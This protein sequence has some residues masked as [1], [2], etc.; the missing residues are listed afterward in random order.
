MTN[1]SVVVELILKSMGYMQGMEAAK[2]KT[3]EMGSETEKLAQKREAFNV[4]GTAAIGFGAAVGSG[5]AM[6]VS[7]F[8][9]FDQAMSY[10]QA[11]THE[12]A[13]NM[14]L[15]RD[16][17]LDAGARTV[18]SATES[19]NA[20]EELSKAGVST[21]DILSGGLDAALDLAA[22][23]GLGVADAAGIAA[24]TLKQFNLAGKDASH[25]ADLLAAGAGK[26]QGDVS[27][28]SQALKQGGLVANQFGLSVDETVGTLS[29][30]ASAGM[31]GSDAGT[32][33]RTM[34][35][36]LANPTGEAAEKMKELGIN[37]YDAQGQF[38]GMEGLAG[39]L[40][41]GLSGLTQEQRNAALAIIFGQDA[42]RGANVL[43][44]QGA[45][46]IAEWT[47]KV[48]DQ[49]YA[50][51][52]AAM[53]LDNLKG[54]IEQLGGALDTAFISMG[55]GANGPMRA[56]VQE[57]TGMVDQFNALP[58]W[59]KQAALGIGAVTAAVGLASGAFLLGVPKVA[60][61]KAAI[62]EMGTGAQRA[63]RILGVLGKTA[64]AVAVFFALAKGAEMAAKGLGQMGNDA[65]TANET[66]SYLLDRDYNGIFKGLASGTDGINDMTDAM[67][68]LLATDPGTAFNRW[69]SDLFAFTGMGS[70]VGKAREQFSLMGQALADLVSRG[71]GDRAAEIFDQIRAK[72]E[73]QGYSVKQLNE[74]MPEYQD[75]LKGV[76]NES[77]L[78][79]D[80]TGVAAGGLNDMEAASADAERA[81]SDVVQALQ[82]VAAG[83]LN[84]GDANDKA[85]SA[86]N[87]MTEAANAQGASLYGTDE[88]SIHLRDSIRAV[89][90][91]HRDSAQAI[92]ENNGTLEEAQAKWEE[93]R[94]KVIDM[95][96]AKGE[97]IAVAREWA[98]KNMGSAAQVRDALNG[99]KSAMDA[100]PARKD[101]KVVI[102]TSEA[103]R[104][105]DQWI[106]AGSGRVI[107]VRIAPDGGSFSIGGFK[108][109][110]SATG[111]LF[112]KGKVK[113]FAA[114]GWASGVG[115]FSATSGGLMRIVEAGHDEAVVSTDPKYRARSV[116]IMNDMAGRLGMWQYGSPSVAA[117]QV[118]VAAPSLEG[119]EIFG[120]LDL[121]NGLVGFVKGIISEQGS[122]RAS[123]VRS[124]RRA[125]A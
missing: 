56:F 59:S 21:A 121:G 120:S 64:G 78:A 27:D 97:D 92:L 33:F 124:G 3:R 82:D 69:G 31:L 87:S 57:L 72:A 113:D 24:T 84:L 85:L 96:V 22:A 55:E 2:S 47:D 75:A 101:A 52:T 95:R 61:Y 36:R 44:Q 86:I 18:F 76:K 99:V 106:K 116:D 123:A 41:K 39:Q 43:L 70:T 40:E 19:A 12:T 77:K 26:A 34:L 11:A 25:I 80:A 17:A 73:K 20:I 60:A 7:K 42:I 10:V 110:P 100:I 66:M 54:D 35:L 8:A 118:N 16:A 23:G 71:E 103:Q 14:N 94:Q 111:N 5:V 98:D 58:D 68:K 49:G 81:L 28:M 63:S 48:N 32:S 115:M 93:G 109:T 88:A 9:Q 91:A 125:D 83:S 117:P 1:R 122:R 38:V 53:R 62:A 119:M 112:E 6:A 45:D 13:G 102:D 79:A 89:E 15:L 67:D 105:L 37:A 50:A 108:V 107:R 51:E 30:F 65:K 46:G 74:L 4:L 29:A 90:Q 104:G 114:G